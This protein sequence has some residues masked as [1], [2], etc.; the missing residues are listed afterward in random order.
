MS[1]LLP[2]KFR[3]ILSE[4][5]LSGDFQKF[6][7]KARLKNILLYVAEHLQEF[8][9]FSRDNIDLAIKQVLAKL[10]ISQFSNQMVAMPKTARL[11]VCVVYATV[12]CEKS[13][14]S[15]IEVSDFL[16]KH[17]GT[18]VAFEEDTLRNCFD[19]ARVATKMYSKSGLKRK[20]SSPEIEVLLTKRRKV[21]NIS[22]KMIANFLK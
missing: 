13:F 19:H 14:S 8:Q 20:L 7:F 5:V 22:F 21:S 1:S 18:S 6:N 4:N 3:K 12:M 10:D 11:W 17:Y 2:G 15:E 16:V 9:P